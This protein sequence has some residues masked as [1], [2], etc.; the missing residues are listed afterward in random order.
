LAFAK[1]NTCSGLTLD[2]PQP[3]RPSLGNIE[4]GISS[5][6]GAVVT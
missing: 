3:K 6:A 1:A 2:G 5:M 4:R